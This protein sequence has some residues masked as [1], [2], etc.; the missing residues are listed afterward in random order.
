[1]STYIYSYNAG[2]KGA[3]S[4]AEQL[5]VSR[6]R[7]TGSR[8]KPTKRDVVINWGSTELP[9]VLLGA[10]LLNDPAEVAK[11]AN[12]LTFFKLMEN[13]K[14]A[15]QKV[16]PLFFT[17]K[18]KATAHLRAN[19]GTMVCRTILNGSGGAGIVLADSEEE[20]V[21]ARL[22]V[23]YIP[24]KHEYRVHVLGG[25]VIDVQEKARKLDTDEVDWRVRNL[26]NGFIY[27]RQDVNAPK[28]VLEV[29]L[30]VMEATDLVFGAVDV[31][32]NE[33]AERA[34]VLECNSAP[35]LEGQTVVNYARAFKEYLK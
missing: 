4:L 13:V 19:G 7:H 26:E 1:M 6:I 10:R 12:K 25:K 22:F 5:G 11:V 8:V 30:K 21:N 16:T 31:V 32:W 29:A 2:S 34:Y 23:R 35:G 28:Q 20:L 3:K 33:K 24:K 27:K 9:R 18:E 17:D 14:L 15:G